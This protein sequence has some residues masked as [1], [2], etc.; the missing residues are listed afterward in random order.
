MKPPGGA[1]AKSA[2][3]ISS[4]SSVCQPGPWPLPLSCCV[5]VPGGTVAMRS[6]PAAMATVCRGK[7]M[8][9]GAGAV[10]GESNASTE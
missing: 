9:N 7:F 4:C 2:E 8:V 10:C 1:V 5:P 6:M 3:C